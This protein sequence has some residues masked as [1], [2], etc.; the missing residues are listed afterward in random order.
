MSNALRTS[1]VATV[2]E[3]RFV[4]YATG[5]KTETMTLRPV[6]DTVM[7]FAMRPAELPALRTAIVGGITTATATSGG[8]IQ[9]PG[10]SAITARGVCWSTLPTPTISG[11]HTTDGAGTGAF[12]SA[13]T[14][15]AS[16]TRYYVRAYATNADGT[17]YG[18]TVS[19]T[20]SFDSAAVLTDIDGNQYHSVRIG[21]QIWLVE[22]LRVTRYLDGTPINNITD[23]AAWYRHKSEAYAD[24]DNDP[25]NSITYGRL[26]NFYASV[27]DRQYVPKGWHIPTDGEW[28][29]LVDYLGGDAVA[30]G[31]LKDASGRFWKSPNVGATNE[32][33]FTALPSGRRH[34]DG[35]FIGK[36][37]STIFWSSGAN[38]SNTAWD[39]AVTFDYQG[40]YYDNDDKRC[41]LAVR[42]IKD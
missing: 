1:S 8:E 22:N 6:A 30:G 37:I 9:S 14:S 21:T 31:K 40:V 33:G 39:R 18:D 34:Y 23:P 42:C 26:Y 15:L 25:D 3:Y 29:T 17:A 12:S 16:N 10:G 5:F 35:S 36:G 19:F 24:Y 38:H 27:Q 7:T 4:A 13:M 20:T 41:G 28:Q 11:W 32:S 2:D